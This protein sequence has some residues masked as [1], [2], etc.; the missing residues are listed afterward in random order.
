M[1]RAHTA[2][3]LGVLLR[4]SR[5][6]DIV[7][8]VTAIVDNPSELVTWAATLTDP[9]VLAWRAADS[10]NR[11]LQVS[12]THDRAPIR[13]EVN[14]ILGC[15]QHMEFWSEL[16]DTHELKAGDRRALSIADLSRAWQAM[17]LT[18]PT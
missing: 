8:D 15:E 12:A 1:Y 4:I 7:G 17:P 5:E 18:P 13:G 14:A 6:L 3:E 16:P 10:G 2:R 11:F 9:Q